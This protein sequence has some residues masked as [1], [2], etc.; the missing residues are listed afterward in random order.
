MTFVWI[1]FFILLF[2][3]AYAAASGAPWVPTFRGDIDRL[4]K[5]LALQDG[6]KFVELGCGD[7]R[8]IL[9]LLSLPHL[10]GELGGGNTLP[11]GN[12]RLVGT[13]LEL[14]LL[15]YLIANIRRIL[16]RTWNVKFILANAF[17][18][19]LRDVDAVYM[20]LM[21]ETYE[22]IRPKLEAELRPGTRVV[23]YVWPIEGWEPL[24]VDE[25]E[26]KSKLYLYRR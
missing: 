9:S 21:P 20:F 25:V 8:V 12:S 6:E 24:V 7:G 23:T 1:I 15:Q 5:L 10:K 4:K 2:S 16:S 13:G 14:S 3:L 11:R 26:G 18:Y 19:D 22:K 17:H